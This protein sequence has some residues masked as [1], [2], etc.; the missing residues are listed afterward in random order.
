MRRKNHRGGDPSKYA[1]PIKMPMHPVAYRPTVAAYIVKQSSCSPTRQTHMPFT[2]PEGE[3]RQRFGDAAPP[4]DTTSLHTG[5][6]ARP[7]LLNQKPGSSANSANGSSA[8]SDGGRPPRT[9]R[10]ALERQVSPPAVRGASLEAG[11][12]L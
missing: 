4:G 5:E 10:T 3:A 12:M 7:G 6:L 2:P 11:R 1:N 8:S 9:H